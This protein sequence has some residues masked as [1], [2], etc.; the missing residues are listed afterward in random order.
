MKRKKGSERRVEMKSG[1]KGYEK[2]VKSERERQID[3][4]KEKT[5]KNSKKNEI[6]DKK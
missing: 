2:N 4:D 6:N 5:E 3:R 1:N